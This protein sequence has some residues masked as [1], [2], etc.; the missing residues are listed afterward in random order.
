MTDST[1][2]HDTFVRENLGR[3][4]MAQDFLQ[5]YLP[6]DI[7]RHLEMNTLSICK[8]T[9]ITRE[10][11]EKRHSDLLYRV[12]T[13]QGDSAF[14]YFLFE[15]KSDR[16]HFVA[17]QLM[18]YMVAIWN[19]H[20]DQHPKCKKLP[21]IIPIVI[22]HDKNRQTALPLRDLVLLPDEDLFRYVP[23]F[24]IVSYDFSAGSELKI[25]G[26]IRLELFLLALRAKTDPTARK[27]LE[28]IFQRLAQLDD[29]ATSIEIMRTLLDYVGQVVDDD[30]CKVHELWTHY[31][32][33]QKEDVMATL[34]QKWR[35]EG[36]I[37]GVK[38]GR[39]EGRM[40]GRFSLLQRQLTRRFGS[41]FDGRFHQRLQ[42][43]SV[44]QLDSWGE[45][46]LD[47]Q[48]IEE[49]FAPQQ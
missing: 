42:S 11:R 16:K 30:Q 15:H 8:D 33:E 39:T 36:E 3:K 24:D 29:D 6:P 14:F 47:A 12:N 2:L 21:L 44:E 32:L 1:D 45:R 22:Y 13:R 38:K 4:E 37:L 34:A 20:L 23:D 7:L 25:M 27:H 46:L 19:L 17:L 35:M 9:F 5:N 48:S 41:A 31:L 10:A 26:K 28:A 49:V 18:E 40:E 43:A